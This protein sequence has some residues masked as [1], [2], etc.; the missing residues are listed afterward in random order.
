MAAVL[1]LGTAL[2]YTAGVA[3][4]NHLTGRHDPGLLGAASLHQALT[5]FA[6][7]LV[8]GVAITYFFQSRE[9]SPTPK[10]QAQRAQRQAGRAPAQAA[11]VAARAAHAV[12]HA[13]QPAGADRPRPPRAQAMLDRLIAFLRATL[14]ASRS[15]SHPLAAE[16]ARI[17]DYLAL[18][19]VRMG[20]RLQPRSSCRAELAASRCRRCCCSRWSRTRS[21]TAWS[22]TWRRPP[23]RQRARDGDT[24]V[25][26]VRDTGAGWPHAR[27]RHRFGLRRCASGSR[28]CTATRLAGTRPRRRAGRG[29]LATVRLPMHDTRRMTTA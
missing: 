17:A 26:R 5:L 24:L 15:G 10:P 18:M 8:P 7:A 25:L 11:R 12:Q 16:F 4:G 28:R 2:G 23:R 9:R 6:L 27:R 1:V 29:T 13:G 21:S 3:L 14:E 19:Q 20:E 22:R